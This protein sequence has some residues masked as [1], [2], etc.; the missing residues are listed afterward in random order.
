MNRGVWW[1]IQ[2]K[3]L[4]RIGH[5]WATKHA[6]TQEKWNNLASCTELHDELA[7]WLQ[8]QM[9]GGWD[10]RDNV[11]VLTSAQHSPAA[12]TTPKDQGV[13]NG[14]QSRRKCVPDPEIC[15]RRSPGYRSP[16]P[17]LVFSGC[18]RARFKVQEGRN[19]DRYQKCVLAACNQRNKF[20]LSSGSCSTTFKEW[21]C[22]AFIHSAFQSRNFTL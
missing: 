15:G 12:E 17:R 19:T 18:C 7:L 16:I 14:G 3:G 20:G 13:G 2:L 6:C 11:L 21:D 8:V 10:L 9:V 5:D 22:R 1:A 4:Q